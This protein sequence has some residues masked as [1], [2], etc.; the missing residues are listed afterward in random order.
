MA[1][2][3]SGASDPIHRL[4]ELSSD[5]LGAASTEG[6]LTLLN[7]AWERTLGWTREELASE[8]FLSFVHPDDVQATTECAALLA[9]GDGAAVVDF[10][11]RYRAKSGEFVS[12]QWTAVSDGVL[13]YFVARDV[14][15][16][17][18]S[19]A[20]RDHTASLLR[21]ITENVADG[22][23]VASA[24]N[25]LTFVNP[26]AVEML[27]YEAPHELLGRDSHATLHHTRIDGSPFPVEECPL[28]AV[29]MT[30]QSIRVEEDTFWRKDRTPLPVSYSSAAIALPTGGTGTVVAFRDISALQ[31]ERARLFAETEHVTWFQHVR[32]ALDEDRFVLYGQPVIDLKTEEEH[33][34]ELLIRMI[35]HSGEIISPGMF[36]P[37]AERYGLINEIDR[38]VISRAAE[39][40]AT[41]ACVAANLSAGS[42]GRVEV[43]LHIEREL[44]RT[45]APAA[46]LTFEVTETALMADIRAGRRFADRLVSL[47]CSFSLDDFGTGYGS[48]TYLR[49]LPITNVKIDVQFVRN[50]A[51]SDMDRKLVAG[52][53]HIAHSLG[54][55][56]I[57]EGVEDRKTLEVLRELGVDRAQGYYIG[58]PA[59]LDRAAP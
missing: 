20:E 46:N 30:G 1:H 34:H 22:L 5:M 23:F 9:L 51:Q 12:I 54:K 10:E 47:G 59:P 58:W 7:P 56:T 35:S 16:R 32:H 52:I 4:F 38:W 28:L 6:Y 53:V 44:S 40:A 45:G 19:D 21:A 13:L 15:A 29:R 48:M 24:D 37:A 55:F 14:T 42:V 33:G 43:L 2:D 27:G 17:R 50:I 57:A 3:T 18:R 36:L 8:P 39:R 49:Q 41:G 11:N 25:Q 31:L 26:E